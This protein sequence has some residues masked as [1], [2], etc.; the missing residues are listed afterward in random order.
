MLTGSTKIVNPVM[1]ER[2]RQIP[3]DVVKGE[4]GMFGFRRGDVGMLVYDSKTVA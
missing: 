2:L 3:W 1:A 4:D